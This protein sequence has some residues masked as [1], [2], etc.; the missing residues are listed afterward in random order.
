MTFNQEEYNQ[1]L[2]EKG[3]VGFFEEPITL[4]SG[5]ISNWYANFRSSTATVGDLDR[6]ATQVL[7]FIKDKG[8]EFDYF[9]GVPDGM[10]PLG[11]ILNYKRATKQNNPEHPII[12]LRHTPKDHGDPK[13]R[14]SVGPLNP[15]A[16]VIVI[17]D[18]TTTGGSLISTLERLK[19]IGI[20]VVAAISLFNRMEVRDDQLS[21]EGKL[22]QMGVA[23]HA[24][25]DAYQMLPL[26]AKHD[27]V[28]ENQLS[29]TEEYF[30]QYG[31]KPIHLVE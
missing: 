20:V 19:D 14:Y 23:Y 8:L 9:L 30:Q 27:N 6:L 25:S 24:I 18:I 3:V 2:L 13:D 26:V 11:M 17:E 31:I 1:F 29:K 21:V 12:L 22:N 7:A 5:R 10:T 4:K 28:P 16:K 15:G